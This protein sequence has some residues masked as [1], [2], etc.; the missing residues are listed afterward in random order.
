MQQPVN[1]SHADDQHG[2]GGS[3][4]VFN[5]PPVVVAL[6]GICVAVYLIQSYLLNDGQYVWFMLNF[7]FI[8]QRFSLGGGFGDPFAWL[9]ALTYSFMHG[10]FAHLAV[11][12]VW[13]AAFGSPL[14]GRIGTRKFLL[15]WLLTAVIAAFTHYA[16][17][18]DSNIP[19]VGASGAISG[20]MGAAARFGFR[21][22]TYY[23]RA[24]R[25]I[26][27]FGGPLLS[28][29]QTFQNRTVLTFVGFWLIIN[30]I[31]GLYATAP[32]ELSGIAW[33][34]HIGGF[35]AGFFGIALLLRDR[36]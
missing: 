24:G 7:A 32:G 31:T 19:L 1:E 8:P 20:M 10:G 17:Y 26:P 30:V 22:V 12:S 6:I 16:L 4:P 18:P 33:E 28:V 14:A 34:A 15:F 5:I 11:N 36:S 3:Q 23:S 2:R 29:L 9:T 35:V 13:F 21:R 27:A 25:Q